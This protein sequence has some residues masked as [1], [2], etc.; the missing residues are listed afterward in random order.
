MILPEIFV[1][2]IKH[3]LGFLKWQLV[4]AG[5]CYVLSIVKLR[6]C[7]FHATSGASAW[8]SPFV[9]EMVYVSGFILCTACPWVSILRRFYYV[10]P[11]S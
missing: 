9:V 3:V 2:H 10:H 1:V 5:W 6:L 11:V 8:L 7:S 4:V